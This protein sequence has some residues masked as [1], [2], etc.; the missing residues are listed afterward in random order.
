MYQ[1][2]LEPN[3]T[4]TNFVLALHTGCWTGA[5]VP[6]RMLP[7]GSAWQQHTRCATSSM[8]RRRLVVVFIG[9][10]GSPTGDTLDTAAVKAHVGLL[11]FTYLLGG[12]QLCIRLR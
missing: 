11:L 4:V 12:L 7:M 1:N 8:I 2:N 9:S 10:T 3:K 5:L 6:R